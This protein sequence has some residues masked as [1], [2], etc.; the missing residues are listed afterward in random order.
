MLYVCTLLWSPNRESHHFSKCYDESW[1]EKLYRG[2]ARNLT[3]PFK[4][5]VFVD[6]LRMFDE[7]IKQELL[8][9]RPIHYGACM[10][11]YRLN[12]PMILVG[13]DT[14]VTGNIDHFADYCLTA[15]KLALPRDPYQTDKVCNGVAL[16]PR[17]HRAIYDAWH[18]ENDMA[19]LRAREDVVLLDD[20]FPGEIVSYKKHVRDRGL[21]KARIV[22]F[23]GKPKMHELDDK[24]ILLHW[25]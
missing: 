10:E 4:F 13:L 25:R 2:F 22:Y 20:L 14:V 11:P 1:V 3:R 9:H 21:G 15:D 16:V 24:D 5:I 8:L 7:P 6:R 18:G 19:F 12:E 23:H 17:G